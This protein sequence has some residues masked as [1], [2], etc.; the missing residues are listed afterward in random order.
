MNEEKEKP[1]YYAIIPANVRYDTELKDKAKL[2]YG[3][4]SAL[5]NKD[6]YCFATNKYFA[7][8]YNVSTTTISLLIKDLVDKGYLESEIIYKDG[9]K[10]ILNRYLRIIKEGYLRNLKEGI[11]ENLKGNNTS[12]NN[13]LDVDS[14]IYSNNL[15]NNIYNIYNNIYDYLQENGFILMPIHYEIIQNWEDNDLTRYAIKKAVLNGKYN[16]NYVDKI[17]FNW[18]K[19]KI[20]TVEQ[21]KAQEDQFEKAKEFR[22]KL[23]NEKKMSFGE[24]LDMWTKEWE[25]EEKNDKGT[26]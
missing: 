26:S 15:N 12:N 25:E 2:L 19:N 4:I 7:D 6:G 11:K 22:E 1:N 17:L 14:N 24:K 13:I 10:E 23:K 21:A 20:T 9:T 5:S 18:K 16:I 3:E 8:L